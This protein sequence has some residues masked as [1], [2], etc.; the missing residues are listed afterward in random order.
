MVTFDK[1][2]AKDKLIVKRRLSK[3]RTKA[4]NGIIAKVIRLDPIIVKTHSNKLYY[5]ADNWV[6]NP[7][8][9]I[10]YDRTNADNYRNRIFDLKRPTMVYKYWTPFAMNKR[11]IIKTKSDGREA[12]FVK[13]KK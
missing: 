4:Y 6:N 9:D 2:L 5:I 12:T 8:P 11:I 1:L 7:N 10:L 13:G 3:S